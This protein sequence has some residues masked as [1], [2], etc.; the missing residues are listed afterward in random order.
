MEQLVTTL[1]ADLKSQLSSSE[2]RI[3]ACVTTRC[4]NLELNIK[5]YINDV[6]LGPI[7][8]IVKLSEVTK[9][10]P[11]INN[12]N[13]ITSDVPTQ[14]TEVPLNPAHGGAS[15]P[16][17]DNDAST[18]RTP[19]QHSELMAANTRT[20]TITGRLQAAS[21]ARHVV[22]IGGLCATTTPDTV[23][24]QLMD[25]G[26]QN[27]VSITNIPS[28]TP[29]DSVAFRVTINDSTIK[30]NVYNARNFSD[31]II[32]KPF[33]F[34]EQQDTHMESRDTPSQNHDPYKDRYTSNYRH[35]NQYSDYRNSAHGNR[36]Y[37][38]P[39]MDNYNKRYDNRY[40]NRY[41]TSYDNNENNQQVISASQTPHGYQSNIHTSNQ[42][43][44]VNPNIQHI[45][46]SATDRPPHQPYYQHLNQTQTT[47]QHQA[48][49]D[50]PH[51]R[52]PAHYTPQQPTYNQVPSA[53]PFP[54]VTT[55]IGAPQ[56]YN[57]N[58][59]AQVPIC[60]YPINTN[61]Q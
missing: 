21:R 16:S 58:M 41:D 39:T 40:N 54:N 19:A 43:R 17:E 37:R 18:T 20:E 52:I 55:G 34:H 29:S 38:P 8:N 53:P 10:T 25:L 15:T 45:A 27:I 26:V 31:G 14:N 5:E 22:F 61:Q 48:T 33:R 50:R 30:H 51:Q 24:A 46:T 11:I 1:C 35:T 7:D 3:M 56:H 4:A 59:N 49:N 47:Y 42:D 2:E 13:I 57:T 28:N 60:P 6:V 9:L 23:R 44:L 32:I 12:D 36:Y